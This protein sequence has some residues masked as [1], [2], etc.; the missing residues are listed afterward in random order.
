M[1][2]NLGSVELKLERYRDAADHL[3]FAIRTSPRDAKA[4]VTEALKN[5][6]LEAQKHVGV[7][8]IRVSADGAE[9]TVDGTPIDE[10]DLKSDVYV[11]PGAH[12]V[13]AT[14]AGYAEERKTVEVGAGA[15]VEIDLAPSRAPAAM[16]SAEPA[17]PAAPPPPDEEGMSGR[18]PRIVAGAGAATAGTVL[19]VAFTLLANGKA[20]QASA[21]RGEL[22]ARAG[23]SACSPPPVNATAC[24]NL[25]RTIT[26][27]GV[28]ATAAA[29]S[30]TTSGVVALGTG[31]YAAWH[32]LHGTPGNGTSLRAWP[33]FGARSGGMVVTGEF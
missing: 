6:L 3:A 8:K 21:L 29:W 2:A 1:A 15:L 32:A 24:S 16:P 18:V 20:S 33:A 31:G 27:Q 11:E 30:F 12:T 9:V 23:D 4:A 25:N 13:A 17:T 28:F 22:S 7:F 5:G 26:S 10:L 14:R 19:G